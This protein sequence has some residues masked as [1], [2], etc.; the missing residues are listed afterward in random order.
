[1][2]LTRSMIKERGLTVESVHDS[3]LYQEGAKPRRIA[4]HGSSDIFTPVK[5][6]QRSFRFELCMT[7]TAVAAITILYTVAMYN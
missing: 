5:E 2:V 7:F 4:R 6:Q 3:Y 1:M